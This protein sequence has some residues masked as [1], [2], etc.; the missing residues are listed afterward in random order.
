MMQRTPFDRGEW[1]P[2]RLN[3]TEGITANVSRSYM[4]IT[5]AIAMR[6]ANGSNIQ[7]TIMPDRSQGGSADIQKATIELMQNRRLTDD[8]N[9]GV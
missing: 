3:T 9:K 5:S 8:D 1:L 6:D 7:V 2:G 4:P